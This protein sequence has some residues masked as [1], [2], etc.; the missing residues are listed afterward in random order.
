M[1]VFLA[2]DLMVELGSMCVVILMLRT[3]GFEAVLI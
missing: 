1:I 2:L 3:V